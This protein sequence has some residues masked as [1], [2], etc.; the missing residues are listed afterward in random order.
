MFTMVALQMILHLSHRGCRFFLDMTRYIIQ[1]SLSRHLQSLPVQDQEFISNLPV[2]P[3]TVANKFP[4][5]GK[6]TIFAVCPNSSC[7]KP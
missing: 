4:L 2:D 7:H 1:L 3:V 6:P 5:E